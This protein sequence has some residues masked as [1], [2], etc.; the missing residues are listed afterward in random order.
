MNPARPLQTAVVVPDETLLT[1]LVHAIPEG[2]NTINV[3]MGYPLSLT[4]MAALM[5]HIALLQKEV[6]EQRG[7]TYFYFKPVL[8]ILNHPYIYATDEKTIAKLHKQ[9]TQE[10]LFLIPASKLGITPILEASFMP[11]T[12]V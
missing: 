10:N 11:Q 8:A 4:P 7:E 1:P 2:I 3:T 12:T 6:R 9:L 5:E